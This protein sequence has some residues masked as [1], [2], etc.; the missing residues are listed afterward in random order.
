M[1]PEPGSSLSPNASIGNFQ[2]LSSGPVSPGRR[3]K[4]IS[5]MIDEW[6]VGDDGSVLAFDQRQVSSQ[7]GL[8]S[9][10]STSVMSHRR[11]PPLVPQNSS[12]HQ[13]NRNP[14][15]ASAAVPIPSSSNAITPPSSSSYRAP[16]VP[17]PAAVSS[18]PTASA[19]SHP[20]PLADL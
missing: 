11:P 12:P 16:I 8:R 20:L 6:A 5:E 17:P 2:S 14:T 13:Q 4:K 1:T 9:M 15:V 7:E 3:K 18:H 10:P 19:P